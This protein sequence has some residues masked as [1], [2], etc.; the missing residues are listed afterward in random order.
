M[1]KLQVFPEGFEWPPLTNQH[2]LLVRPYVCDGLHKK[3]KVA[4]G[5]SFT[6]IFPHHREKG[7]GRLDW[8]PPH[9]VQSASG[10]ENVAS[11]TSLA[12]R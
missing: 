11:V 7:G 3:H 12:K 2:V 8:F 5:R 6:P 1:P 10:K 4:A 9:R